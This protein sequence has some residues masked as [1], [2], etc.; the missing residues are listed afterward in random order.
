MTQLPKSNSAVG[1]ATDSTIIALQ[2]QVPSMH[3]QNPKIT[4]QTMHRLA[5]S[6]SK[7]MLAVSREGSAS[8]EKNTSCLSGGVSHSHPH[9]RKGSTQLTGK[10]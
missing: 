1:P 9:S 4:C 8:M 5:E 10:P 6:Q 7:K 3:L 2:Q